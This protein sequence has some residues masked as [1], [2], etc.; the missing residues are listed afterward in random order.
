[1]SAYRIPSTLSPNRR[2]LPRSTLDTLYVSKDRRIFDT[3]FVQVNMPEK[4][5]K[6]VSKG[7]QM[8]IMI[9]FCYHE[10]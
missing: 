5:G 9:G 10:C 6:R 8:I 4:F 1:V 7:R 3:L 2:A